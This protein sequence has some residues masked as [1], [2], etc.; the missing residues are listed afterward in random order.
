MFFFIF[1]L[2]FGNIYSHFEL[3]QSDKIT[4]E[5][6]TRLFIGLSGAALLGII[7]LF[8]LR[9]KRAMDSED[10]VNLNARYV[11]IVLFNSLHAG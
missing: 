3:S 1:S 7:S 2:I 4:P 11:F 5:E 10:L 8:A 6:R 9:K